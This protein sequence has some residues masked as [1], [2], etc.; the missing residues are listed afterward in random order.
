MKITYK[1]EYALRALLD[2]SYQYESKSVVPLVDICQRQ[3]IPEKYLEQIMLNLKKAGYVDSKRGIGGGFYLKKAPQEMTLGEV[4]R[5]IDGS[6]EPTSHVSS[7]YSA[8]RIKNEDQ[9]AFEEV[10]QQ[11]TKAISDIVDHVTFAD[12][13]SR[14]VELRAENADFNYII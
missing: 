7:E 12:I 13:M 3:R 9:K 6:V 11:V 4:I 2:L 8:I 1:G 10:W 14:A 5:L